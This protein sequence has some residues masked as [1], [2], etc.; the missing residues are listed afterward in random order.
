MHFWLQ[1]PAASTP[2]VSMSS[3]RPPSDVTQ[4]MAT[5]APCFRA[6]STI[7]SIGWRAPVVVST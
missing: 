2:N 7:G 5:S 1:L 6:T 3:G 4:S